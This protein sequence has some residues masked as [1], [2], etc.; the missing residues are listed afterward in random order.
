[1]MPKA[2]I[3]MAD[4]II[5][6]NDS[7]FIHTFHY[8]GIGLGLVS[9]D[10]YWLKVN[11]SLCNIVGYTE[12]ELLKLTFHDITHPD[13]LETD[14]SYI[15]RLLQG[16]IDTYQMEK[17]YKHKDGSIIWISLNAS[18]IRNEQGKPMFFI[19][20][21]QD[22]TRRKKTE[23]LL[24]E[25]KERYQSLFEHHPDLIF[26]ISLEGRL[27]NI[28]SAC[29]KVTGYASEEILVLSHIVV[30]E[31]LV[32]LMDNV[33][34]AFQGYPQEYEV[35]IFHK[36]GHR[37]TLC[38]TNLPIIVDKSIIGAYCIAKDVTEYKYK[39]EKLRKVEELYNLISENSKDI[40][41]I[42]D[43]NGF[44]QYVSPAARTLMG[45]EPEELVGNRPSDYW[46]S[47]DKERYDRTNHHKYSYEDIFN[48]RVRHK[49]GRYI[50]FEYTI[51]VIRNENGEVVRY[52]GIGRDISE[53]IKAEEGF[54][55]IVEDSPDTVV[56]SK[57]HQW[58]YINDAGV[59]LLGCKN[60]IEALS[61]PSME[62][63]A[64]EYH[65]LIIARFKKVALGETAELMEQKLI[66]LDGQIIDVES[67][68]IPTVF[69]GEPA[70]Y[71]IIRDIT[72]RKETQNLMI[73]SEKLSVA[74]QL[75]AGI[76]HEIRNPLTA[77]KGFLQLMNS[78]QPAKQGYL[79]II[80]EEIGRIEKI[81]SELL[82]LAKPQGSKKDSKDIGLLLEQTIT[83]LTTEAILNNVIIE[84]QFESNL[85]YIKCDESQLKQ[86]F[87]NF[88]KNSIEAMPSGG[89]IKVQVNR[90]S[91]DWIKIL[92]IDN[93]CGIPKEGLVRLGEP[94]YTTKEKGTGLGLMVSRRIIESHGGK[95]SIRS[96]VN[97]GT[98]VEVNFQ[99]ETNSL[100]SK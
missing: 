64:P 9:P 17:R 38:I 62:Y 31:D 49:D 43:I 46:H 44:Y 3:D 34:L 86:V 79:D 2:G 39:T 71:T 82:V 25:S 89:N 72:E 70:I 10:G 28:N 73:N 7:L 51:K 63:L 74:G 30:P 8:A 14:I 45:Y 57:N 98:T 78:G 58:L 11:P 96:E 15:N 97:V 88:I 16:E 32:K 60:K 24:K 61:K 37:L 95:V 23:S 66:R 80:S 94:F 35:S 77:I 4:R 19:R 52:L 91:I 36:E 83:L 12:E 55:R 75:A 92:F 68:S 67:K 40:I 85:P 33:A 69:N 48:F 50:E 65:D 47:E 13:D 41:A 76:A 22:I 53:R 93:G 87:I 59:K 42:C 29:K 27:L 5:V 26:S 54:R 99:Y 20:E 100:I 81:L 56:I 1:M 18:L 6:E 21:V 84:T 90:E